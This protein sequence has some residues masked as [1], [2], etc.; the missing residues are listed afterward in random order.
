MHLAISI[1]VAF[2]AW[3]GRKGKLLILRFTPRGLRRPR[4]ETTRSWRI[5]AS[6]ASWNA[7][8]ARG[9]NSA[10]ERQ[11]AANHP[12]GVNEGEP[13]RIFA[14][15]QRRFMHQAPHGKVRQQEPVEFLAYQVRR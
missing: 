11:L 6:T 15:F 14:R 8:F 9:G 13:V 10:I 7:F 1:P 3:C 5:S 12:D 2:D 4:L